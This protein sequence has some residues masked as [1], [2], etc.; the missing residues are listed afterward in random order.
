VPPSCIS[1]LDINCLIYHSRDCTSD[2][3]T[4]VTC[5]LYWQCVLDML[6]FANGYGVRGRR[7]RSSGG[8][9]YLHSRMPRFSSFTRLLLS[10]RRHL[11]A[12]IALSH[13]IHL[14]ITGR[15]TAL[16]GINARQP[17]CRVTKCMPYQRAR[18]RS[19]VP[20]TYCRDG[21]SNL[22]AAVR[23]AHLMFRKNGIAKRHGAR[24]ESACLYAHHLRLYGSL[25][26]RPRT[27]AHSGQ[28]LRATS[29]G[30]KGPRTEA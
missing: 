16:G 30:V 27:I 29:A 14:S 18:Y 20:P 24:R 23:H 2:A 8:T 26:R 13:I 6:T 10:T 12:A 3:H 21:V 25:R 7:R 15:R 1:S 22:V 9:P 4:P 28:C 11:I 17:A 19:R 5:I